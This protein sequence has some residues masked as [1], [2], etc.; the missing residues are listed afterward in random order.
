MISCLGIIGCV[1]FYIHIRIWHTQE[2]SIFNKGYD[3][4]TTSL[5]EYSIVIKITEKMAIEFETNVLTKD[6]NKDKSYGE[7]FEENLCDEL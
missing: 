5:K 1:Y 2:K 7:V 6:E 3:F 4:L